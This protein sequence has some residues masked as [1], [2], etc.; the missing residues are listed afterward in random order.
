MHS[1]T[2]GFNSRVF[3]HHTSHTPTTHTHTHKHF[4]IRHQQRVDAG[5]I[6]PLSCFLCACFFTSVHLIH[7]RAVQRPWWTLISVKPKTPNTSSIH[8]CVFRGHTD[9]KTSELAIFSYCTHWISGWPSCR[10]M[11]LKEIKDAQYIYIYNIF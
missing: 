4:A 9:W 7:A 2:D 3:P 6:D 5:E 10:H 8:R 11:L 1:F